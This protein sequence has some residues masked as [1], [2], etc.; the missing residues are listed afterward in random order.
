MTDKTESFKHFVV[1]ELAVIP[2][3]KWPD[4]RLSQK[5]VDVTTFDESL[6]ELVAKLLHTMKANNGIGLAA[7]QTGNM[8]NLIT[9]W[10]EEHQPLALVNPVITEVSEE[11]FEFEEGCLSVPGWFEKR[12]RPTK[13]VVKFQDIDGVAREFEFHKLYAFA[14]Q[15]EI[16]HLSGKMFIDGA[17]ELK[18][19][20][21]K[22]KIKKTLKKK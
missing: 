19:S 3:L 4:E 11:L 15:H 9:I 6:K 12:E 21:I 2:V 10:I 7:P 13:I 5:S 16:D 1:D 18:K 22:S 14:I 20:R 17:S 8:I